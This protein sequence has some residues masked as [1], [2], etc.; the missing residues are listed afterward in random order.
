MCLRYPVLVMFRDCCLRC[1]LNLMTRSY[2]ANVNPQPRITLPHKILERLNRRHAKDAAKKHQ[3]KRFYKGP[4]I[5]SC[6]RKE[7]NHYKGQTY[8][9]FSY[10]FLASGGWKHRLSVGD[11]FTINA[12][13]KNPA[14]EL[15]DELK[16]YSDF[17]SFGLHDDLVKAL[18]DHGIRRPTNVQALTIPKMMTGQNIM[19]T[20]ETGSGKTL[21]YLLPILNRIRKYK[22][23]YGETTMNA[24]YGIVL[25]PS[26]ELADQIYAVAT[27]LSSYI[28]CKAHV[29]CG[30][31]GT[32]KLLRVPPLEE[33]DILMTTPG[34]FSKL[35]T[36]SKHITSEKLELPELM[37]EP[38]MTGMQVALVS[39][40][41]PRN[42]EEILGDIVPIDTVEEVSTD[43]VHQLMPHV[44]QKFFRVSGTQKPEEFLKIIKTRSN[45]PTLV[46]CKNSETA[47][48]V[49]YLLEQHEINNV[50]RDGR[51]EMMLSGETNILV[52]T[53]IASRGLDTTKVHLVINYDFPVHMSDYIHR[54]GRVGRVGSDVP[55]LV[56]SF[57]QQ[58]WEVN[59]LWKIEVAARRATKL[60]SVDANIKRKITK[61]VEE[62]YQQED[63]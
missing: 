3:T 8:S 17:S 29:V 1:Y 26:R 25:V 2:S 36:N 24:P 51:Y 50:V 57:I 58:K 62:K 22:A 63:V 40:T 42:V 13:D 12:Y 59:L 28:D 11:Y 31:R 46:F 9:N 60:K 7:F 53:D 18:N 23:L 21:A 44:S 6:K 10:N 19:C 32:Q 14:L 41:L 37:D 15:D 54:V 52:A 49:G 16:Q 61:L 47:N 30:G 38:E 34:V 56:I 27:D 5:I 45:V 20:A 48:F 39:A 4:L 35:L 43:S 55:G 33:T